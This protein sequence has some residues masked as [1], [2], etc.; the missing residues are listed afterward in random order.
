[1][2]SFAVNHAGSLSVSHNL[3]IDSS[4]NTLQLVK[5]L[6]KVALIVVAGWVAVTCIRS[7]GARGTRSN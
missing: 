6:Q 3:L 5:E 4:Q 7:F 2:E 1:M